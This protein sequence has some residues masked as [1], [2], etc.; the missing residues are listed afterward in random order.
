MAIDKALYQ[1]P[2]GIEQIGAEEEPIEITIE[3]PEAV[4]IKGPGFEID[5]QEGEETEDFSRNLA[6][7]MDE[8]T[9]LKIAGDL[10]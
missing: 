6:E 2:Q 10:L 1:A 7:E 8:A 5:M 4:N 3:D 9:L